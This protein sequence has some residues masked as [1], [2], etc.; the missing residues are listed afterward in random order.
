VTPIP[1]GDTFSDFEDSVC[2]SE[3]LKTR[4]ESSELY[5]S[6]SCAANMDSADHVTRREESRIE[7]SA[8]EALMTL[9]GESLSHKTMVQGKMK[10]KTGDTT[11]SSQQSP[12]SSDDE[13]LAVRK[14]KKQHES[15]DVLENKMEIDEW[16][17]LHKVP[18]KT[19]VSVINGE[20]IGKQSALD[21][22]D[23]SIDND[24]EE[25]EGSPAPQIAMEHSYSLPPQ[26]DPSSSPASIDGSD[27]SIKRKLSHYQKSQQSPEEAAFNH[28]HGYM[29]QQPKTPPKPLSTIIEDNETVVTPKLKKP[30]KSLKFEDALTLKKSVS[31][32]SQPAQP[33]VF[34]KRDIMAEMT[35]LYEFL[36]RGID[37]EDISYLKKSY[38]AM[39]ADDTQGYWLNDT[40]WV[41]H[42]DILLYVNMM[43]CIYLFFIFIPSY[44]SL[45]RGKKGEVVP[46]HTIRC[47]AEV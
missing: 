22:M 7:V 17:V 10:L 1:A 46:V 11:E 43:I 33:V 24:M 19:H 3:T 42:P 26:K 18:N 4:A 13:A 16:T 38:E 21:R 27:G 41:D 25:E 6:A 37:A 29:M 8:I 28:D 36:T 40:H 2:A 47:R 30:R 9:A 35:V 15:S 31:K 23:T 32:I 12:R 34:S 5:S 20:V 44:G 14:L 45:V 39:L